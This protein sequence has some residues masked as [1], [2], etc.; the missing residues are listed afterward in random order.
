MKEYFLEQLDGLTYHSKGN[1]ILDL[2]KVIENE[3][4][5]LCS[6]YKEEDRYILYIEYLHGEM[7]NEEYREIHESSSAEE[8]DAY[9]DKIEDEDSFRDFLLTLFGY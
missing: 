5:D 1:S 8:L 6:I 3:I 7:W 4:S 2:F 9:Y